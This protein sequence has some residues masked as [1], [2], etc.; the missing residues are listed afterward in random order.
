DVAIGPDGAMYFTIGGRKVQSGLYR[1]TYTG[2]ESTEPAA[3]Q[4]NIQ[5]A[6]LR[7]VRHKLA[8]F[9][10]KADPAAVAA[11]WPYLN[12]ADR[13]IRSAARVAIEHQPVAQWK[14]Q[15]LAEA[16]PEAALQSLLALARC[17]ELAVQGDLLKA[18][19]KLDW[20]KLSEAQ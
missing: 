8:Q 10:G 16:Q 1:V 7:A 17:G 2:N 6:E 5:A 13:A 4:Q 15:A 3:A 20:E 12:H 18:L 19:A 9:H 14:T 11:A